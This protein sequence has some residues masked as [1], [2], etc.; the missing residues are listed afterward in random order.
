MTDLLSRASAQFTACCIEQQRYRVAWLVGLPQR[1]RKSLLA[2]QLCT[3]NGWHYLNFTLEPGYF[4]TLAANISDYQPARLVA[5]LQEWCERS[6][7]PVLLVDEIDAV[8]ATWDRRRRRNWAGLV[9]RLQ[10][11]PRGL[12]LVSHFFTANELV[13]LLPDHDHRYCVDLSGDLP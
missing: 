6:S 8:L 4:D 1:S 2:Q 9:A 13:E 10:Y 12:I 5:D 3:R 11:L 7:A